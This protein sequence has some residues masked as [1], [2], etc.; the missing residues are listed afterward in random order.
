M[1]K[2]KRRKKNHTEQRIC[3]SHPGEESE[4]KGRKEMKASKRRWKEGT[5]VVKLVRK[6]K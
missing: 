2:G 5:R 4:K 1:K 6:M 3:K